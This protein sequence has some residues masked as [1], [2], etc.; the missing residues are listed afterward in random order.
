MSST[1]AI[2]R[3]RGNTSVH[4]SDLAT[5]VHSTT[6]PQGDASREVAAS[7]SAK[8]E[9]ATVQRTQCWSVPH[10]SS[11]RTS[12]RLR[13][14]QSQSLA[15]IGI[16]CEIERRQN[17][18]QHRPIVDN[19]CP[20]TFTQPRLNGFGVVFHARRHLIHRR[21]D[22]VLTDVGARVQNDYWIAGKNSVEAKW[23]SISIT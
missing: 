18:Q 7:I 9:D 17:T 2:N 20:D 1:C 12:R 6:P 3:F 23:S 22:V 21:I 16:G 19:L 14:Q 10:F 11:R 13:K 8:R 5:A 15:I 4:S